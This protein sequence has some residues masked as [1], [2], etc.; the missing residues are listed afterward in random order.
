[1]DYCFIMYRMVEYLTYLLK[2]VKLKNTSNKKE[3]ISLLTLIPESWSLNK[4]ANFFEVTI[5][6]VRHALSVKKEKGILGTPDSRRSADFSPEIRNLVQDFYYSNSRVLPGKKDYVSVN[7][8]HK[9]KHLILVSLRELYALFK[10]VNSEIKVGY[11][12]FCSL[13]PLEYI[14]AGASGTH[15]VCVC[16]TH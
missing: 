16:I 9:K 4:A 13:R 5:A 6:Q 15:S 12:K 8:V 10:A 11:S 2:I 14:G 1:M 7:G 3:K